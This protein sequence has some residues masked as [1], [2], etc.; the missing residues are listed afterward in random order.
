MKP[1]VGAVDRTVRLAVGLA[2]L[3][4]LFTGHGAWHWVG[5]IG[6][7]PIATSFLRFCPLYA[8]L[9]WRTCRLNADGSCGCGH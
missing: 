3:S 6:V 8:A 5:L 4:I 1:N 9:G 7:V 2:L